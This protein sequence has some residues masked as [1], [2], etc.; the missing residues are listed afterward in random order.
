MTNWYIDYNRC[1]KLARDVRHEARRSGDGPVRKP[2]RLQGFVT[3]KTA[4]MR[5]KCYDDV[6]RVY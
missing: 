2:R 4:A 1:A 6:L 5:R 3:N